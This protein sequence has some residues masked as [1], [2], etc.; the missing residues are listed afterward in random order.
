MITPYDLKWTLASASPRRLSILRQ[1]GI[2]PD[3]VP[4]DVIEI[5]G[6]DDPVAEAVYNATLKREA[7]QPSV[8]NGIVLSADTIVVVEK[9]VLGKPEN[10]DEAAKM[11]NM[12]SGRTHEVISGFSL[13]WLEKGK[14]LNG[15]EITRV[16]MRKLHNEEIERYVLSGEPMDKAGAYGIQ[17]GASAFVEKIEGCYF[18]VVGLP[19]SKV[20]SEVYS[21]TEI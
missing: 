12:L 5:S 20:I 14:Q 2:E 4:A 19:V 17:G 16:V 10:S 1:I 11:L 6:G 18:N 3:V 13:S 21:W 7:I 9:K 8:S 15:Y